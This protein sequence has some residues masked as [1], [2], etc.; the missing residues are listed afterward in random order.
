MSTEAF[1]FALLGILPPSKDYYWE[2]D[3]IRNW[4][5]HPDEEE[6]QMPERKTQSHGTITQQLDKMMAGIPMW[7]LN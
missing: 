2:R 4:I 3:Y 1:I 5:F 7:S 6:M